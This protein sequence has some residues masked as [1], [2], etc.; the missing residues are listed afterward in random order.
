MTG[1]FLRSVTCVLAG[2]FTLE[3]CARVDDF[4]TYGA[5][6][7]KPYNIEQIYDFDALGRRGKPGAQYRK[8]KLNSLGFRGPELKADTTRIVVFGASETFGLYESPDFE[9]P[10]LFEK[11]LNLLSGP[12]RFDVI[13]AAYAG[14]SVYAMLPRVPEIAK[15]L[16]PRMALIYATPGLYIW[17][18]WVQRDTAPE[19]SPVLEVRLQERFRTLGKQLV[20]A[21]VQH[22]ARSRQIARTVPEYGPVMDR[23]P[24]E[25]VARFAHDIHLLASGLQSYGVEPVLVTHAH[26][27]HDPLTTEDREYLTAWRKFY[28]MLRESGFIDMEKRMNQAVRQLGASEG[29]AVLDAASHIP[30]GSNNFADFSHFTD[31]G[32]LTMARFLAPAVYSMIET[33]R[34]AYYE[35]ATPPHP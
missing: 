2:F 29:Y 9:F 12:D 22:W 15:R 8:W 28:P 13:N 17:L 25:N 24:E 16:Q 35:L 27:F 14:M 32:S 23:L 31:A 6:L 18:P 1:L 3:V 11:Q 4:I 34:T 30:P 33:P 7:L 20:P 26:R 19:T 10:R 5:P 21:I